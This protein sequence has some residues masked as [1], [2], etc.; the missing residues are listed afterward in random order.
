[1]ILIYG[2]QVWHVLTR[3]HTVLRATHKCLT[4][5]RIIDATIVCNHCGVMAAWSS[6]TLGKNRFF[7]VFFEKRPLM[8]IFSKFSSEKIYRLIDRQTCRSIDVQIS[9]NLADGKSVKS[10]VPYLTPKN[11]MSPRSPVLATA[12]FAPKICQGQPTQCT[13]SAPDFIQIGSR[14]AQLCPNAWTPSDRA[15]KW[16]Q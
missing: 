4:H 13:Q 11:K 6:K 1:M 7:C 14:S 5:N 12:R 16:I 15:R 2:A 9:W 8:G 10:C 3:D